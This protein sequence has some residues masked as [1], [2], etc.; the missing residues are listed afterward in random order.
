MSEPHWLTAAEATR[1]FAARTLS[2]VELLTALLTRIERLDPKLHAFIRLD[3][4]AAMD[5]AR[6][7]ETEIANGR[8]RGPLHGVPVGIKDI[9]DVAGLPTTCHSK[10]LVGNVAAADAV[11]VAKL[12]QAGAIILGKLSHPRIRHRRAEL[13]SAVPAGAQSVEP[14]PPS[15]RFVLRLRR[16]CLRRAVSAARS[17]RTPAGRCA[18]RPRVRHRRPEADLR[19]GVAAR[20]VPA[21]VHA[22]PCRPT[23]PH[24][25][26]QRVAAGCDRR[27]RS[28][29][30]PAARRPVRG[31]SADAGSRRAR[32]AHRLRAA[33]PRDGPAGASRGD[34]GPGRRGTRA[35]GGG[36]E[37]ARSRCLRST[38]S[39]R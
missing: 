32:P 36:A 25:R 31:I 24:G 9:I 11:V 13:R 2:P 7:A 26:R 5:A 4:D 27:A 22:R 28:R 30:I 14:G 38:S 21:V 23:D 17:A 35:A 18:T 29:Q 39:P 10:I 16:R 19:P 6:A 15:G 12:R 8:V 33:F 20:R 1:R 37:C 3:A 34:R